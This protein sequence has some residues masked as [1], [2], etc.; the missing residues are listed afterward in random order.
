[1]IATGCE[2]YDDAA[3]IGQQDP[4]GPERLSGLSPD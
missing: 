3:A 1:M 2:E 4:G